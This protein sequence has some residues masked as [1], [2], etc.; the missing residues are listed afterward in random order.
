MTREGGSTMRE[1]FDEE[2]PDVEGQNAGM[3]HIY[4]MLKDPAPTVVTTR[5]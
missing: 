1:G 3:V 4:S 5:L 2:I